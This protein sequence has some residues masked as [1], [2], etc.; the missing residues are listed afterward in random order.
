MN[1]HKSAS[2]GAFFALCSAVL[3][4]MSPPLGKL[5]LSRVQPVMLAGLLYVGAAAGIA[6]MALAR[7][8]K[9]AADAGE[10]PIRRADCLPLS[11]A[12]IAGGIVAPIL[13]FC[14][15]SRTPA[16]VASLLLNTEAVMTLLLAALIFRE[17]VGKRVW[18]AAGIMLVAS[19]MLIYSGIDRTGALGPLL[20]VAACF[21]WGVDNNAT[22]RL[23]H[24]N[25][26][27][28]A[29]LKGLAAGLVA[30][31]IARAAHEPWP[32][33]RFVLLA[34]LLGALSYGASI[35]LF[36]YAMRHI[37]AARTSTWFQSAPF[38][39][40]A[41]SVAFLGDALTPRLAVSGLLM[42]AGALVLFR[43]RHEHEHGHHEVRHEHRH[44][45]DDHHRHEHPAGQAAVTHAH[46]HYHLPLV[47]S[48]AHL[49]DLHHRHNH[50]TDAG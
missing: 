42:M 34:L 1:R 6:A 44:A 9:K 46:Q 49:P 13:L 7:P 12:I 32:E 50:H 45:H 41:I 15:L 29:R 47:H 23:A 11:V 28:I 27:S 25:P 2:S 36:V 39:G 4:G 21:M 30:I 14:G 48:H 10:A 33:A 31:A 40:A 43:E 38:A 5:L 22:S 26:F 17:W 16:S 37:G 18:L 3:F 20:V 24:K 35:V 19:L 8:G